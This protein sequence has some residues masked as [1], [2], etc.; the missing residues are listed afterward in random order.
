MAKL[1]KSSS[2]KL[3]NKPL[4]E[5]VFSFLEYMEV[6]RGSSPLTVRNYSHYLNRF[7]NWNEEKKMVNNPDEID[8]EAIHHYRLFL[9]RYKD[10]KTG[11]LSKK[12]QGYH[13][14]A[15][16][17]FLKWLNK[18]DISTMPHGNIDLP[19]IDDRKIDFLTGEQVDKLLSAPSMS[20]IHGKRDKAIL[21]VLFSTGLRVSELVSLD[22]DD[23]DLRAREFGVKGKGGKV[24]VVFLSR[25]AADWID[26]YLK[27]RKDQFKPL[28]IRHSGSIDPTTEDEEMRLTARSVQRAV[29]KYGKKVSIPIPVT[30]HTIRHSYATD[31]LQA[32]ADLRSV[33]EMLGHKNVTTT[34]IYT[35]VTNKNLKE[36]YKKFHSHEV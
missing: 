6:E 26:V 18:M 29:K 25:R 3:K 5:L 22:I 11:Y 2:I 28:F 4:K 34:Q 21:E 17:S 24:R 7:L 15:M 33:Q 35:H 27:A 13:M 36:T 30:P 8:S 16:R 20:K 23:V 32:G 31:L 1:K 14:I 12:T 9:A 19:K 10:E